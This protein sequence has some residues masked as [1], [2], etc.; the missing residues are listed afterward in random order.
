MDKVRKIIRQILSEQVDEDTLLRMS[1]FGM[2]ESDIDD[3]GYVTLYHGGKALP[4]ELRPNEI[5]FMTNSETSAADYARMRGGKVFTILAKP[6]D[7][8]WNTGPYE[9]EFDRGGEFLYRDYPD[10]GVY[11]LY[12]N[13]K[14]ISEK[15]VIPIEVG[16]EILG[17]K[18][19]NKK[20]KV[21]EIGKNDKGEVTINGKPLMRFRIQKLVKESMESKKTCLYIHGLGAVVNDEVKSAMSD[22]N[23]IYPQINYDETS[24]PYYECIKLVQ[25]NKIDF[26]VGHSI[27]GVM[28]YWLSKETNIP[29]LLL[30]PAF[31]D[32]YT[33]YVTKSIKRNTPNMMAI[34]GTKDDEVNNK[35]VID[36]LKKQPNCSIKKAKIGHDISSGNLK[37]FTEIFLKDLSW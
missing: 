35:I 3:R 19:K 20:V 13:K 22:Y 5:F 33:V 18:F 25:E 32:D 16:D 17:G 34:I 26:I 37:N 8:Y 27:G 7:L 23:L 30:C 12:P 1:D 28:A 4:E 31:G 14:A 11:I 29:S 36:T 6:E 2:T 24:K 10:E 15:I 21:K 9:I